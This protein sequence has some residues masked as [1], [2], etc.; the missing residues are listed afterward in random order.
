MSSLPNEVPESPPSPASKPKKTASEK[1][2][3]TPASPSTNGLPSAPANEKSSTVKK[4]SL[5]SR[6]QKKEALRRLGINPDD[7][8]TVPEIS[9]YLREIRGGTKLVIQALRFSS[10]PV[11]IAFL[12]KYDS[13]SAFDKARLPLE[14][15]ALAAEVDIRTLLGVI[16][17]AVRED[18]VSRVKMIAIT[19]HPKIIR[20]RVQF[21]Q[22]PGGFRDRDALDTMLGALPSP[23]GPTFIGKIINNASGDD[24][25][26]DRPDDELASSEDYIFPDASESQERIQHVRQKLLEDGR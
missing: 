14:A 4:L 19:N 13:I 16:L 26:D 22:L 10:D 12:E 6:K 9:S 20:S 5:T 24:A 1:A 18:S 8:S 3:E 7:L 15:I 11:A 17:L 21:A 23:K 2:S 25:P